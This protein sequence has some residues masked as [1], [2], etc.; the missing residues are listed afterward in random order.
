MFVPRRAEVERGSDFDSD[1]YVEE[2]TDFAGVKVVIEYDTMSFSFVSAEVYR[3]RDKS[4]LLKN[5]GTII[6]FVDFEVGRVIISVAVAGAQPEN[7]SG[8]GPIASVSSLVG[9]FSD[10]VKVDFTLGDDEGDTLRIY[11][12]YSVDSLVWHRV[13]VYGDTILPSS[14]YSSSIIWLSRVD[15]PDVDTYVYLRITPFD[16]D[17]GRADVIKFHL[18]NN[19]P[20]VISSISYTGQRRRTGAYKQDITFTFNI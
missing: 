8:S 1:V 9:E 19:L 18:D 3:D 14:R 15:L 4:I 10:S 13:S 5:G 20:P 7:V 2:S 6:D 11:V 16:R 12:E 17:T